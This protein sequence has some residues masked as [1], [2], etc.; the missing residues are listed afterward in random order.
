MRFF[1]ICGW[2]ANVPRDLGQDNSAS[3]KEVRRENTLATDHEI[4]ALRG[5]HALARS[6]GLRA[7][8]QGGNGRERD[9]HFLSFGEIGLASL[10]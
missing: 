5:R 9:G 3:G 4:D 7:T 2:L 1:D 6:L 10:C 8:Q